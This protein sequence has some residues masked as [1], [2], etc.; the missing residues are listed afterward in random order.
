MPPYLPNATLPPTLQG[1]EE[2]KRTFPFNE[3]SD[4]DPQEA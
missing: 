4:T 1:P 2:A 3:N